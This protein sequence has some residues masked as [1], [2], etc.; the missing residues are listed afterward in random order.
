MRREQAEPILHAVSV[1]LRTAWK[2]ARAAATPWMRREF[3]R[4]SKLQHGPPK[5]LVIARTAIDQALADAA[6]PG[7][8]FDAAVLPSDVLR[9]RFPEGPAVRC[10]LFFV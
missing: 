10:V 2:A 5:D 4:A 9:A 3:E 1:A 8:P 6:P 7:V